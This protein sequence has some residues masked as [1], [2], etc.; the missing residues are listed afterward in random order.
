MSL[1]AGVACAGLGERRGE[2]H[3]V[4]RVELVEGSRGVPYDDT[5]AVLIDAYWVRVEGAVSDEPVLGEA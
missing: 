4:K 5:A 3:G 1:R 2:R